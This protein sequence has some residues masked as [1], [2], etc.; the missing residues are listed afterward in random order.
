MKDNIYLDTLES[1]NLEML[2]QWRNKNSRYGVYRTPYLLT[3]NM[4]R[5]F[6][7]DIVN[8]RKSNSRFFGIFLKEMNTIKTF[9]GYCGL[10]NIQWENGLAEIALTIGQNYIGKGYGSTALELI[11]IEA[12][13]NM[14]IYNVYGECYNCNPNLAFWEKMI[15][16]YNAYKTILP[17]RK[18]YDNHLW[19]SIYFDFNYYNWKN[20]L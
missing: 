1:E 19:D 12:F 15:D 7:D 2:R 16:K 8:D 18:F 11:L 3:Y 5:K 6:F 20:E 17:D 13:N 4:Q 10:D 9:V 14:R